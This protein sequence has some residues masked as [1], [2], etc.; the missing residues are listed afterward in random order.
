MP[1]FSSSRKRRLWVWALVVVVAIYSTADLAR[2]L[3]DA[4]RELLGLTSD[5]FNV[6]MLLVG[7]MIL[8]QGLRERSRGV[9]VGFALGVAAIAIIGFA[10]GIS[11]AERSHLI[12]Y[13]VLAL[14][15]HEALLERRDQG[16]R[17]PVPAVLAIVGTT[18]AG[19]VNECIQF[20]LPSRVIGR[21]SNSWAC[22]PARAK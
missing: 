19:V 9:E 18:P 7:A 13:T 12:E 3:A 5:M 21:H 1:D 2:M 11:A 15:V 17:V 4:L 14:I 22:V 10:R 8:V 20:F 6:G 16:R